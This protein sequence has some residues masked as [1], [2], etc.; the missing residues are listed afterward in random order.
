MS[1]SHKRSTKS[2]RPYIPERHD[3]EQKRKLKQKNRAR[4]ADPSR[5]A[6]PRRRD[7]PDDEAEE[8][9]FEKIATGRD[10]IALNPSTPAVTTSP[11]APID[12]TGL[13]RAL[14]LSLSRGRARILLDDEEEEA[15]LAPHL[16]SAQQS[17]LAVGDEVLVAHREST[18]RVEGV[19]PRR[20]VL[21]RPDPS[22]PDRE[23]VLA[24]N[25]DVAIL[26]L[27]AREPAFRPGLIDRFLIAIGRG[28]VRPLLCV[29][30]LDLVES[31][32]ERVKIVD[33]LLPYRALDVDSVLVSA[34]SGD[35]LDE[36][37]EAVRGGTGVFVGHSGVGK[38]S[39]LNALDPEHRRRVRTGREFDGKGRHTTTSSTLVELGDDTRVIDT[40]GIRAFGLWRIGRDQLHHE[41]PEFATHA[42]RCRF[43]DCRHRREP[44]CA[45]HAA[46]EAGLVA[47]SRYDAYRR[48]LESLD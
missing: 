29:N 32:D 16:A 42:P 43:R 6:P 14:V 4:R 2:K 25:V 23:R 34:V 10:R 24:A 7:W 35:G 1:E 38:S 47:R 19:R 20:S 9:H 11:T 40:P 8:E 17:L 48:I 22:R 15:R 18:L 31:V 13:D 21:S 37:R 46:V 12:E 28:G 39:L 3:L 5:R 27:S 41:F 26:V 44:D 36:V 33:A 30:K 45:V